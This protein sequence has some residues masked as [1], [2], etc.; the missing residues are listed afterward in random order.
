[1][2]GNAYEYL[3]SDYSRDE[4]IFYGLVIAMKEHLGWMVTWKTQANRA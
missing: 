3:L 1:L 4:F 2:E